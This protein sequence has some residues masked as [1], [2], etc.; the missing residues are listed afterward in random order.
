MSR[1]KVKETVKRINEELDL[2]TPSQV[3]AVLDAIT[4]PY[5]YAQKSSVK[6]K[7]RYLSKIDLDPELKSYLLTLEL[8]V[9]RKSDVLSLCINKFGKERS[10]SYTSLS[11]QFPK[12]LRE[13]NKAGKR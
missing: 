7:Q 4:K 12:L 1:S 3:L 9:M 10:P 5:S 11:R 2:L 13:I 6:S 8:K